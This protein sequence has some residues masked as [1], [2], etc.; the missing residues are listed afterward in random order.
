M[1]TI[2]IDGQELQVKDGENILEACLNAGLNLPYFCWHPAMGSVGSCRQ[3]ALLQYQ[4]EEDTQGRI[5]MGCMTSVS[6]GARFSVSAEKAA[7]FR[8][9]VVESLMLNHPHDCPVCA[10]GGECHLQDMT[11]MVGHRD[12]RY[13]GTKNTF[14]NQ[15][16]GPLIHHEMNRCITCYRCE[17]YYKDYAGGRDLGAQASHDHVYFGRHEE[18]VLESE[19]SGNLVEV[20]PTGVFTDKPFLKHY[21][22]KWDLQSAPS[23]C[24]GCAVGCNIA[25]GERYGKLKRIHNRYNNE[26]NGYFLCDRGRFGSG[27]VN[28]DA[29]LDYAGI[30]KPDDSF[31]A[32]HHRQAIDTAANWI[33]GKKDCRHRVT[34]SLFGSELFIA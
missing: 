5:V 14:R 1:P 15:Y 12:R 19:F 23:I 33:K 24:S 4:N 22:R 9:A 29:R 16:L 28:S 17:R 7:E 27:Y 6:E 11:V 13:T 34:S 21:S 25:P 3:C 32:V 18:G 31:F 8:S 10:E 20:C 2:F 26:V 30:R